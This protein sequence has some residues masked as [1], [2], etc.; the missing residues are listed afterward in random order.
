MY[1][2]V[3]S[4]IR[5]DL[6]GAHSLDKDGCFWHEMPTVGKMEMIRLDD[7]SELTRGD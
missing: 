6:H 3:L 1:C 7:G 2:C 4:S 5:S